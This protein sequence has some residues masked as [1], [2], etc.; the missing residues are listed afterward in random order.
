MNK[1]ANF[2]KNL[3]Q[4]SNRFNPRYISAYEIGAFFYCNYQPIL[5]FHLKKKGEKITNKYLI[6][7]ENI[8]KQIYKG[9]EITL[10]EVVRRLLID[11]QINLAEIPLALELGKFKIIGRVDGLNLKLENKKLIIQ[12]IEGKST[13]NIQYLQA[14]SMEDLP[15]SWIMQAFT[16][17]VLTVGFRLDKIPVIRENYIEII[18]T[19]GII[20]N[21]IKLNFTAKYSNYF[22]NA[23]ST[24][25]KPNK[26]KSLQKVILNSEQCENCSLREFCQKENF[27]E[28]VNTWIRKRLFYKY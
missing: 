27:E 20:I 6:R 26:I 16:Y 2:I 12:L 15:L 23:I 24:F 9:E 1:I 11:K 22:N 4:P 25:F 28:V 3:L 21:R 10:N 7:G 19:R 13:E 14:S 5:S 8:H 18:N 17:K